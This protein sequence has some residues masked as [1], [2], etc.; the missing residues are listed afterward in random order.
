MSSS[1]STSGIK[2][3]NA[4]STAFRLQVPKQAPARAAP[5]TPIAVAVTNSPGASPAGTEDA[6]ASGL[7]DVT[8]HPSHWAANWYVVCWNSFLSLTCCRRKPQ[9]RKNKTWD[10]DAYVSLQKDKLVMIS[11]DGK[12]YCILIIHTRIELI[13]P[14]EWEV[15]CGKDRHSVQASAQV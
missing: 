12:M 11:E 3:F 10:G 13:L 15:Y 14:L 6:A 2:K 4:P 7:T 5:Q 1:H 8:N 9:G